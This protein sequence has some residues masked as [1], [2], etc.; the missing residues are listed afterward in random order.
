MCCNCPD[1]FGCSFSAASPCLL[2]ACGAAWQ[3][4]LPCIDLGCGGGQP[5][6]ERQCLGGG[7]GALGIFQPPLA[8]AALLG[9]LRVGERSCFTRSE[10][11]CFLNSYQLK[12]CCR[13]LGLFPN[14]D[15][16]QCEKHGDARWKRWSLQPTAH[17][18]LLT[19]LQP[20]RGCAGTTGR[21]YG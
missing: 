20:W 2:S 1:L 17:P 15:K 6:E 13:S 9:T 3:T 14:L 16:F 7:A 8:A 21:G 11:R 12:N 4:G 19:F 10:S 5:A 18:W